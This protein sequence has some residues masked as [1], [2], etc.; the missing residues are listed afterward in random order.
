MI[1]TAA[2]ASSQPQPTSPQE[3]VEAIL[4]RASGPMTQREI[5]DQAK[6]RAS[7]IGDALTAL[8][9]DGRVARNDGGRYPVVAR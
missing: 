5:R 4:R 9:T 8:V 3:R 6:L 7:T 1:D 2:A